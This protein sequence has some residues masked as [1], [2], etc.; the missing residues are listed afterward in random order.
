MTVANLLYGILT[1]PGVALNIGMM[2][3]TAMIIGFIIIDSRNV[4]VKVVLALVVFFF[5]QEWMHYMLIVDVAPTTHPTN[6][7]LAS[8]TLVALFFTSGFG[9][10]GVLGWRARRKMRKAEKAGSDVIELIDNGGIQRG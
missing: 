2:I 3:A 7:A 9:V 10:G 4:L 6:L 1:T 5:F 8:S